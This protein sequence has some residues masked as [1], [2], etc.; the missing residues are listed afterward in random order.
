MLEYSKE[1]TRKQLLTKL[2][3]VLKG[4]ARMT[5]EDYTITSQQR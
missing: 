2:D 5:L 3:N 1:E 4:S